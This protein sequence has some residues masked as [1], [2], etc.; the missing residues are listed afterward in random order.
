MND[1][2]RPTALYSGARVPTI[3]PSG[4]LGTVPNPP[5]PVSRLSAGTTLTGVVVGHDAEGHTLVR[6]DLGT[7]SVATKA[8]LPVNSEVTLQIRSSGNQLHILIMHSELPHGGAKA[9]LAPRTLPPPGAQVGGAQAGGGGSQ[10]QAVTAPGAGHAAPAGHGPASDLLTLGQHV[11]AVVQSPAATPSAATGGGSGI[12]GG[13]GQPPTGPTLSALAAQ[14]APG[15]ELQLRIISVQAPA[16]QTP[17]TQAPGIQTPGTQTPGTQTPAI[18]T[19]AIQTAGNPVPG[20][21]A[22]GVPTP[23]SQGPTG[24]GTTAPSIPGGAPGALGPG[25]APG[26]LGGVPGGIGGQ[27]AAHGTLPGGAGAGGAGS[28]LAAGATPNGPSPATAT[29]QT[30][31]TPPVPTPTLT[32][33]QGATTGAPAPS[34]HL[35]GAQPAGTVTA[36]SAVPPSGAIASYAAVGGPQGPGLIAAASPAALLAAHGMGPSVG[37]GSGPGAAAQAGAPGANIAG[38]PGSS[39]GGG[40]GGGPVGAPG[41]TPAS[42]APSIAGAASGASSGALQFTGTVTAVSHAGQPVLQTPLGTLTLEIRTPLQVGS[43]IIFELPGGALTPPGPGAAGPGP[44]TLGTLAHSWPALDETLR[45]LREVAPPGVAAA[46]LHDAIPQPGSRLAS[47]LLFFLSA[48]S[49]GDVV[50]WL[51]NQASQALKSAGRDSL[52][53]RLAQDFGQLGRLADSQSG[54]WRLFFIPLHD[55]DQLQQMR[56]FLRH[57]WHD[58]DDGGGAQDDEDQTRFVIEVEMSRLGEL[59]LDGLVRDKRLDLILRS[60]AP[61]PDFMRLDI[62]QIFHETNEITGNRGTISFQSSLEWKVMPIEAPEATADAGVV[63]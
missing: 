35:P 51:G 37:P 41:G 44:T 54:D 16:G 31:Q 14:L 58:Q 42:A 5:P 62:M 49:G 29:P 57:G 28:P 45:V 11:R 36:P 21:P 9:A 8:Q 59:Q 56:L 10:G 48:L 13:A 6:T 52:L 19:P 1:L 60:R 38:N 61:L 32:T 33:G 2:V 15:S 40:P 43:R 27:N 26:A 20:G 34:T 22:S 63:V 17:G 30:P 7:L 39:P 55:G 3:G 24:P 46:M 23:G 18:Q 25:G 12:A 4:V 47:G 53:S 50:R